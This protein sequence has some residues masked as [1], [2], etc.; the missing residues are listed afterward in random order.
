LESAANKDNPELVASVEELRRWLKVPEGKML[1]WQDFRRKV[2][3]QGIRQINDS[4]E[5]AGFSVAYTPIKE[6]RAIRQVRFTI[7]K[8]EAREKMEERIK[9]GER[10]LVLPLNTRPDAALDAQ[11]SPLPEDPP[12][13]DAPPSED[14]GSG[15]AVT[16]LLIEAGLSQRD[17]GKIGRVQWDYVDA[18]AR[19]A[20]AAEASF[21]R[22]IREKIDLLQRQDKAP[23]SRTGFLLKAIRENW[24]NPDFAEREKKAVENQAFLQKMANERKQEKLKEEKERILQERDHKKRP[25]CEA[26]L[27]PPLAD[28]LR[29]E[30]VERGHYNKSWIDPHLTALE[31][32]R[33]GGWFAMAMD[34]AL[35]ERFPERFQAVNDAYQPRLDALDAQITALG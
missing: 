16:G 26:L 20:E 5:G 8:T 22:Y 21:E 1:R 27:T 11:F 30:L 9:A 34:S 14:T 17:A 15:P 29:D 13:V 24:A 33:N 4:P 25:I 18:A 35:E 23:R 7:T 32:Y 6:G 31:N 12:A 28:A 19:P 3:E 10:Q 2:L